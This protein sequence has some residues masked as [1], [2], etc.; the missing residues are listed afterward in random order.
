MSGGVLAWLSVC[1]KV[2]TCIW[3]SWCHCYSLSFASVKSRLVLPF[4]YWLT[5][6]VPEKGP[7]NGCVCVCAYV[8]AFSALTLLVGRQEGHP[9]C[10]KS[11]WWGVGMVI[12]LERCADLHMAQLILLQLASVKSRLVL[13]FWYRLTCVVPDKG[14]LNR[15]VCMCVCVICFISWIACYLKVMYEMPTSNGNWCNPRC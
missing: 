1:S 6:V 12:C 2:Q 11:E 15:C 5:R 14:S 9:A 4:W 3:P 8:C 7:L 10:K 13:P